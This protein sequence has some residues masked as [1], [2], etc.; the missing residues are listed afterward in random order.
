MIHG[1]AKRWEYIAYA[2]AVLGLV[3]ILSLGQL[4]DIPRE[5]VI[6]VMMAGCAIT[7]VRPMRLM[8]SYG[9][10]KKSAERITAKVI[11]RRT[12]HSNQPILTIRFKSSDGKIHTMDIYGVYTARDTIA[13]LYNGRQNELLIPPHCFLIALGWVALGAFPEVLLTLILLGY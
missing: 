4:I 9:R 13:V 3:A 7:F 6:G 1:K 8:F 12:E 2:V 10:I 11:K 5:A